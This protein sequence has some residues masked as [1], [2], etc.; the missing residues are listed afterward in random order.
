[1]NYV[2]GENGVLA[3]VREVVVQFEQGHRV[4]KYKMT[5]MCESVNTKKELLT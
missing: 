1:M 5:T 4:V 2:Y 3:P